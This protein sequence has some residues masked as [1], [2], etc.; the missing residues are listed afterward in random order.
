VNNIILI[1]GSSSVGKTT[2]ARRLGA[3]LGR[4][5]IELDSYL[6]EIDDPELEFFDG[7]PDFWDRSGQV[8]CARLVHVAERAGPH[9]QLLVASWQSQMKTALFEG[10][11]IHPR[12]VEKLTKSEDIKG[13]F[14]LERDPN[15]L[16]RTLEQRSQRFR[17]LPPTHRVRVVEMNRLYGQW[18]HSQAEQR[19]IAWLEAQPWAT[20][21]ERTMARL[22]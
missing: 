6:Q 1:G 10:E 12:L 21:V 19:Q 17:D 2:V 13:I 9:I 18:L 22:S 4:S 5:C 7:H 8:L 15:R 14:I 16:Y 3:C 11:Q 20:L